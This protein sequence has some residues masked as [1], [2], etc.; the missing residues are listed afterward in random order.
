MVVSKAFQE[1]EIEFNK[2]SEEALEFFVEHGYVVLDSVFGVEEMDESNQALE[3]MRKKY[4]G[5]MGLDLESYDARICQWRDMWMA[6]PQ[7]DELLRDNRLIQSA[8][9]FMRQPSIQLIHDHVIRKPFSALNS[10]IPWHQDYPFW[11]VDTPDAL[12]TWTPMEDV[13]TSGGCLELSLSLA[14][15]VGF[16]TLAGP[17]VDNV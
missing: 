3:E 16:G 12:S 2:L 4:A 6:E 1:N 11:P 8:Q 10:T 7:F 15:R 9:F 5:D 17:Q 14:L 13:T